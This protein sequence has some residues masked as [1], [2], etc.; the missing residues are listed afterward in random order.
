MSIEDSMNRLAAAQ[1]KLA[2]AM[3]HYATV[4]QNIADGNPTSLVAPS[5][6][7]AEPAA[8]AAAPATKGKRR[9]K[10][11]IEADAAKA[12]TAEGDGEADP[13]ATEEADP[14]ADGAEEAEPVLTAEVI[15][16][17]VLRVKEKNTENAHKLLKAL[18]VATLGAIQE[19]DYPR[20]VELAKKVGVTL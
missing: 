2:D 12:A 3:T 20:V 15:R 1:E 7:S 10:A 19:K 9:T 5:T 11:E 4:M 18:G 14:F 17:L 8:S 6:K 16:G 13:F